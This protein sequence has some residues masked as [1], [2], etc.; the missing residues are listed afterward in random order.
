MGLV[1]RVQASRTEQRAIGGVPW[2]LRPWDSPWVSFST[3]GPVHPSRS[4]YGVDEGLRLTPLYACVRLIAEYIASLPLKVYIKTPG[5]GQKRW[6][7]PSIFD[8]PAPGVNIMDW[9][10]ECLTSLLLHG[11]AWGYILSRDGY[12]FPTQ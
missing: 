7:G 5:G 2:R 8:D 1:E 12:G 4:L 6:D 10:Y 3:G 11:N 9:L